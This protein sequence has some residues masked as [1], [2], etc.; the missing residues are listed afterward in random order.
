M[1]ERTVGVCVGRWTGGGG[2]AGSWW[3]E[4]VGLRLGVRE[5]AGAGGNIAQPGM[6][7]GKRVQRP[8]AGQGEEDS[9]PMMW[10]TPKGAP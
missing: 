5:T 4:G 3:D 7:K 1:D 8:T 2:G 10:G 9:R 6:E